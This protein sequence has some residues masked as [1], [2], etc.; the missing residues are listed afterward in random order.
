MTEERLVNLAQ[1]I[2]SNLQCRVP[3]GEGYHEGDELLFANPKAFANLRIKLAVEDALGGN[4]EDGAGDAV[5]DARRC[6][7]V[8]ETLVEC[9]GGFGLWI[10]LPHFRIQRLLLLQIIRNLYICHAGETELRRLGGGEGG[11]MCGMGLG[12]PRLRISRWQGCARCDGSADS[13][14]GGSWTVV[15]Q[16]RHASGSWPLSSALQL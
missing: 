10:R 15:A 9:G 16:E 5:G 13:A 8:L 4:S 1:R 11:D 6:H 12:L 7:H 3:D 14:W 2:L